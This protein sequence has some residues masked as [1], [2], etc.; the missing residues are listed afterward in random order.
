MELL[1]IEIRPIDMV[2]NSSCTTAMELFS[3]SLD[4]EISV[5]ESLAIE[6]HLGSC[7][8]CLQ[9]AVAM[10][11]LH[12]SIWLQPAEYIPDLSTKIIARSHPPRAGVGEW[13]RWALMVVG[14]TELVLSLPALIFGADSSAPVHVAR[15]VGSLGVAFVIG[16]VYVAWKPTRAYGLLPFGAALGGCML[17]SSVLDLINN[18]TALLDESTH[19][20]EFLGIILL[21]RLAGAPRPKLP[22]LPNSKPRSG[23]VSIGI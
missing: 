3:A 1:A 10:S 23:A 4:G 22:Q 21:W 9:H 20:F 6:S 11:T 18:E 15:H 7:Q 5:G 16:L 13:I 19:L 12:R 14:L 17:V 2:E 8:A